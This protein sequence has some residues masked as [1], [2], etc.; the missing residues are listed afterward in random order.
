MW[1]SISKIYSKYRSWARDSSVDSL[2]YIKLGF[3]LAGGLAVAVFGAQSML[4][5]LPWIII[6]GGLIAG[7]DAFGA[8]LDRGSKREAWVRLAGI[9]SISLVAGIW[10][11]V[12]TAEAGTHHSCALKLPFEK[13]KDSQVID[14]LKRCEE[15]KGFH[16]WDVVEK[17]GSAEVI[18]V[19]GQVPNPHKLKKGDTVD[20]VLNEGEGSLVACIGKDQFHVDAYVEPDKGVFVKAPTDA[21]SKSWIELQT[22]RGKKGFVPDSGNFYGHHYNLEVPRNCL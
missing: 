5:V 20:I 2:L 18:S 17:F 13:S 22:P 11:L 10:L 6:F 3:G 1:S 12:S 14:S 4:A 8:A 19:L 21:T 15:I 16:P 9:F 7:L